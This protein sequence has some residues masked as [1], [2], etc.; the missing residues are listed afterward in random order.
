MAI[1]RHSLGDVAPSEG[2]YILVGHYG[3]PT[4]FAVWL[5]KGDR[6][7]LV[8][9]AADIGPLWYVQVD[10]ADERPRAA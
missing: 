8:I 5:D 3:E 4:D 2:T 10:V 1:L 6:L 9:V 7:P